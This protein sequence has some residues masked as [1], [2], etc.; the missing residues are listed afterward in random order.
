MKFLGALYSCCNAPPRER[1]P[2]IEPPE[3]T[4]NYTDLSKHCI[5]KT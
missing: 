5:V 1:Q 3:N 2:A 4:I